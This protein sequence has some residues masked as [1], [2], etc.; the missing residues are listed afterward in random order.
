MSKS[1]EPA[2]AWLVERLAA[3]ELPDAKA[4][5]LQARVELQDQLQQIAQSNAELLAQHPPAQVARELERRLGVITKAPRKRRVWLPAA[6]AA[7][8]AVMFWLARPRED[9]GASEQIAVRGLEPHLIVFRKTKSG[10]E[11]L[12]DRT[13]VRAGDMLQLAYVA[14]G[15][16]YGVIASIDG[17]G[18]VTLHLPE[19]ADTAVRLLDQGQSALPHAFEL[20]DTPGSERFVFVSADQPFPTQ[21]A[22]DALRASAQL[23]NRYR[24]SEI[25]LE[26][27]P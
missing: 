1:H 10:A 11:R 2:P 12:T 26:K 21:L 23:D 6:A 13:R 17:R 16:K 8:C 19:R 7:C 9:P 14:A 18:T 4:H 27:S 24:I 25:A 3:G 15:S 20:D 5:E 22:I